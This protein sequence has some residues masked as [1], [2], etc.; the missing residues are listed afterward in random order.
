MRIK[1]LLGGQ[2]LLRSDQKFCFGL[3]VGQRHLSTTTEWTDEG[4][5]ST[6]Y[7]RIEP[8]LAMPTALPQV[9][10]RVVFLKSNQDINT[11]KFRGTRIRVVS[12][13]R[14]AK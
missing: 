5:H 2:H 12:V 7:D 14:P 1:Q 13:Y 8:G 9:N 4:H 6:T 3:S 10:A 11:E